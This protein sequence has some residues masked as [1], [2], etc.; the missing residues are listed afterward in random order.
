[1]IQPL[2][3]IEKWHQSKDPWR[4]ETS[5]DDLL[6]KEI[7]LSELPSQKYSDVLDIGC[8]Q[9]FITRDLPGNRIIGVDIAMEATKKARQYENSRITFLTASVFELNQLFSQDFDLIIITGVL[10]EHYIGHSLSLIYLIVDQLLRKNG[11]L[12][13]VHINSWYQARFPYLLVSEYYYDYRSY[14]HKL[15]IYEK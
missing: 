15:E 2:D 4:Y 11:I 6:R 1:M 13:S 8:G 9:G 5:K 7:L 10:Y 12:A 3:E 14:I